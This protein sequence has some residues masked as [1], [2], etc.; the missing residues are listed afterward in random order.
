[1][2]YVARR[3]GD[4]WKVHDLSV[5]GTSLVNNYRAQFTTLVTRSSYQDLVQKLRELV[6]RRPGT[7]QATIVLVGA[8]DSASCTSDGGK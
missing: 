3:A 7:S 8:G 4:Q 1:V 5:S 6:G 2:D